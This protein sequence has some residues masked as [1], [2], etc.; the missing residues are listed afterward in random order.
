MKILL[1]KSRE[2]SVPLLTT[3]QLPLC[4]KAFIK[5]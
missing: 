3:T 1:M 2:L 5:S 4:F